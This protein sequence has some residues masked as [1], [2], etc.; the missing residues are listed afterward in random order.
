MKKLCILGIVLIG[1]VNLLSGQ[2]KKDSLLNVLANASS[3]TSKVWLLHDVAW[4]YHRKSADSMIYYLQEAETLSVEL[5][6]IK[7]QFRSLN[8]LIKRYHYKGDRVKEKI[9]IDKSINLALELENKKWLERNY[10]S[11]GIYFTKELK[12]DSAYIALINA[13]EV[14]SAG[15]EVDHFAWNTNFCLFQLFLAQGEKQKAEE[16]LQKAYDITKAS[17]VRKDIGFVLFQRTSYFFGQQDWDNY[18]IASEE[19][20]QFL[21][22]RKK[23][24][25]TSASHKIL[26][27]HTKEK[28]PAE[29]IKDIEAL[30]PYNKE[31]NHELSL[32]EA[33]NYLAGLKK[34][35]GDYEGAIDNWEK[36]IP[37]VKKLNYDLI[38]VGCYK[39]IYEIYELQNK[40]VLAYPYLKK[41]HTMTDSLNGIE[42][43]NN[44]NELEVKYETVKKDEEL[45]QKELAL[46]KSSQARRLFTILAIA[47]SILAL[48]AFWFLYFKNKTNRLLKSQK[49][50]IEKAL[51]EKEFL[52]KEI[53]HRVKNNLQV[54]SSLLN[55]QSKYIED[56]KALKS[57][58]EGRNRVQSMALIHQNLYQ[59]DNLTGVEVSDYIDKLGNSLFKSYNIHQDQ[60]Q[61]QSNIEPMTLDVDTLIPLGLI[62]NELLSN[63][64]KHAFPD[65]R[66]GEIEV[67]LR[68]EESTL[69]LEVN[70]NGVGMP[71]K[72]SKAVKD[73]FGY[74]LIEAFAE[75]LKAK[76]LVENSSGTSVR[77]MIQ[78]FKIA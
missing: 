45:A 50:V 33:Y 8:Q 60:I 27:A 67:N 74:K 31:R 14:F 75:K 35:V 37:I 49:T 64:L 77:L 15:D 3:D 41:Y 26:F 78:N 58:Q 61:F 55:W 63:A 43:Q 10:T 71:E 17:N 23:P 1:M 66:Y 42:V 13:Q 46:A 39:N 6:F 48:I 20:L 25:N 11:Q 57:M 59:S 4:Q 51:N 19:Y 69:L 72:S 36:C 24:H 62:L 76:L 5:G 32:A 12:Y 18:S 38:E 52:L 47:G 7:G 73:S 44:M 30:I 56:T 2:T 40:N 9:T 22:S 54:I 34:Q 68:Q 16:Y 29:L 70:D 28:D 21:N 53:H 65:G